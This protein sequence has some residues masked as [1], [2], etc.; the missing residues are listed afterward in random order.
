MRHHFVVAS[1][2][3]IASSAAADINGFGDFSDFS[4]NLGDGQSSPL[5]DP[6]QGIIRITNDPGQSRS[7]FHNVRQDITEFTASF[8]YWTVGEATSPFGATF[9]VHNSPGGANAVAPYNSSGVTTR[10]GLSGAFGPFNR[11]VAASLEFGSLSSESSSTG[12]YRDGNVG[13]GSEPTDPVDI[14]SQNPIDVTVSYDGSLLRSRFSD[15][16]TGQTFTFA[17]GINIESFVDDSFAYVGFTA[18]GGGGGNPDLNQYI[19]NFRFTVPTPGSL[20]ALSLFGGLVACRR[21]R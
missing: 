3:L 19:S 20:A 10:F 1:T 6:D 15:T 21:R 14:F 11:S 18:S 2:A 16:V 17:T 8:T 12:V 4:I 7:I 9:V 5:L 13:G